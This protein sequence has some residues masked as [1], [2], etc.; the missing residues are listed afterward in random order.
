MPSTSGVQPENLEPTPSTSGLQME[1]VVEPVPD[2]QTENVSRPRRS[3]R[4]RASLLSEIESGNPPV[5]LEVDNLSNSRKVV[6]VE[7]AMEEDEENKENAGAPAIEPQPEQ[8]EA[9]PVLLEKRKPRSGHKGVKRRHS[10]VAEDSDDETSEKCGTI[11]SNVPATPTA[12]ETKTPGRQ[13]T[14]RSRLLGQ[15]TILYNV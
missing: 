12:D 2:T 11:Q 9:L 15:G 6:L 13:N 8:E 7:D 10:Q 4:A 1:N 14:S 5:V 3:S